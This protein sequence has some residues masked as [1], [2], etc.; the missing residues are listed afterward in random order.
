M[1]AKR[2]SNREERRGGAVPKRRFSLGAALERHRPRLPAVAFALGFVVCGA[3]SIL[4]GQ[5]NN[6]DLRNYHFYNPYAFLTDRIGYD[7]APAQRQSYLNPLLDL[8]FYFGTTHLDPRLYAFLMGGV[9]GLSFGLLFAVCSVVF[10][11]WSPNVRLGVSALSAALGL[12]GPIFVGELGA[13]ENDTLIN[14]FVLVSLFL[15]VKG[16]A[17]G[18]SPAAREMRTKLM[19]ASLVFGMGTGLKPTIAP[20]AVGTAIALLVVAGTWRSRAQTLL[21]WT[22]AFLA[23]FLITNGFWMLR[24]WQHFHNPFFPFYND[25]FKSPWANISSYADRAM[26]PK[27][28]GAALARPFDLLYR[29]DYAVRSYEVRDLRYAALIAVLALIVVAW[30]FRM[31]L[32]RKKK[33][34]RWP[35]QSL[36]VESR[37][38]LIAFAV[39][40][41]VWQAAFAIFR[42]AATLEALAPLLLVVLVCDLSRHAA[43]RTGLVTLLFVG[44]ALA[45]TPMNQARVSFGDSFWEVKVSADAVSNPQ[46]SIVFLANPRPWAYLAAW[47]PPEVRW[48][49][50][51]NNLTRV[52]DKSRTQAEIRTLIASHQG[53]MYLLSRNAPSVWHAYDRKV[54][55]AYG[56]EV[57]EDRYWPIESKHSRPG[58]RLWPLRPLMADQKGP[59]APEEPPGAD[60]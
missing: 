1:R 12:Y 25:I 20:F 51:N 9:H 30:V 26:V 11:N 33:S 52:V 22:A 19:V 21:I 44:T 28:V 57:V 53:D 59:V 16:L 3:A 17:T 24:L 43:V 29:S 46:N 23:G 36:S 42:Y 31:I 47:F 8:P 40:F 55:G 27:T 6:W 13:S 41:V 38:L 60:P 10:R 18:Q 37:F 14:L 39:S 48:V 45:M 49:G 4:M 5:D 58:L 56:L 34:R 50:M 15:L 7:F 2:E 54:M 32:G 35:L